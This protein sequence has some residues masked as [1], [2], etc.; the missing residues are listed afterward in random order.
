MVQV[1]R[2]TSWSNRF[3]QAGSPSPSRCDL[4]SKNSRVRI[5]IHWPT[6]PEAASETLPPID[7]L[8]RAWGVGPVSARLASFWW[9]QETAVL[10][11][12]GCTTVT[13]PFRAT[14][15][16]ISGSDK[17][18]QLLNCGSPHQTTPSLTPSVGQICTLSLAARPHHSN[19]MGCR[20]L[21]YH[22]LHMPH[23]PPQTTASASLT[24]PTP[25]RPAHFGN[26]VVQQSVSQSSC[27]AGARI[28][29]Q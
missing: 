8:Q 28:S 20:S 17:I 1:T 24:L 9:R 2:L 7:C 19:S 12:W 5:V 15:V 29:Y 11:L 10:Q 4:R 3:T 13:S 6:Q 25:R 21:L 26:V 18:N 14:S 23:D 22:A 16:I 27:S